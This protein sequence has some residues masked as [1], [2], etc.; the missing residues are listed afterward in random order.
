MP[1]IEPRTARVVLAAIGV[2]ANRSPTAAR[3]DKWAGLCPGNH[4][5]IGNAALRTALVEAAWA[6]TRTRST[7]PGAPVP[8]IP[9]PLGQ[10]RRGQGDLPRRRNSDRLARAH[11]A[12]ALRRPGGQLLHP[13]D[14]RRGQ[15][16]LDNHYTDNSSSQLDVKISIL[17]I[18]APAS[19][20]TSVEQVV[21]LPLAP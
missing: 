4:E 2:E 11:P 17:T 19:S 16:E 6:A 20:R 18:A 8:A 1:G 3:L 9:P 7:C 15:S 10:Q 14:R 5:S 13:A 21:D 12:H